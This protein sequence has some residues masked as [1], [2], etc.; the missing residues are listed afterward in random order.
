[1]CLLSAYIVL[2]SH[3][4]VV[5]EQIQA[6][7]DFLNQLWAAVQAAGEEYR[8]LWCSLSS[9]HPPSSVA[10]GATQSTHR[11][12]G[13]VCDA[14]AQP[15]ERRSSLTGMVSRLSVSVE[16]Q[17]RRA[18]DWA[19]RHLGMS[20]ED[21]PATAVARPT[22]RTAAKRPAKTFAEQRRD[23]LRY[24]MA[25]FG[26]KSA[27]DV[28]PDS[29]SD[30]DDEGS[31][32]AMRPIGTV[33]HRS[34]GR[35]RVPPRSVTPPLPTD[36]VHEASPPDSS[37]SGSEEEG[38][39]VVSGGRGDPAQE[40]HEQ[41]P[42][43]MALPQHE[44][45]RQA[46]PGSSAE[47]PTTAVPWPS[48]P[49]IS[50]TVGRPSTPLLPEEGD[51]M[52]S[53]VHRFTADAEHS[54]HRA[55]NFGQS[56]QVGASAHCEEG[57]E[58]AELLGFY[59]RCIVDLYCATSSCTAEVAAECLAHAVE[60]PRADPSQ[61]PQLLRRFEERLCRKA[62]MRNRR[63]YTTV[64]DQYCTC[65]CEVDFNGSATAGSPR[66][67]DVSSVTYA[68]TITASSSGT[69]G[70]AAEA[71]PAAT[72]TTGDAPNRRW[73]HVQLTQ[74]TV[75][76][77]Q[78]IFY[79]LFPRHRFIKTR[80]TPL[81]AATLKGDLRTRARWALVHGLRFAGRTYHFVAGAG[82]ERGEA[83]GYWFAT[84]DDAGLLPPISVQEVRQA[85]ANFDQAVSAAA[86]PGKINAR[87]MLGFSPTHGCV[88]LVDA[89]V[90]VVEDLQHEGGMV[91]TDGCGFIS[92]ALLATLPFAIHGGI[93]FCARVPPHK[94]HQKVSSATV[95][96]G[97]FAESPLPNTIQVRLSCK[98]GLFKGCLLVTTDD[99]LC[100][101][102]CVVM[103]QSMLKVPGPTHIQPNT[104]CRLFVN[105]TFEKV[106]A[107]PASAYKNLAGPN[108]SSSG[109]GN[110]WSASFSVDLALLL[111]HLGLPQHHVMVLAER[112]IQDIECIGTQRSVAVDVVHRQLRRADKRDGRSEGDSGSEGSDLPPSAAA[113]FTPPSQTVQDGADDS[114]SCLS[115]ASS[116]YSAGESPALK[117]LHFLF[118]G[119]SLNEPQLQK[120]LSTLQGLALKRLRKLKFHLPQSA[121]LVGVPDPYGVLQDTEVYVYLPLTEG[122]VRTEAT[123][124]GYDVLV[125]R[126]PMHH[127]GDIRKLRA[128][129]HPLLDALFGGS[130]NPVVV[131]ST[132]G[133]RS[134][135]DMMG[136]GDFD[137]DEYCVIYN[138][139]IVNAVRT[140]EPYHASAYP[141]S[142]TVKPSP[143]DPDAHLL[144]DPL[145]MDLLTSTLHFANSNIVG[146]C[147]KSW[148]V[149]ADRDASS[150]GARLCD[151]YARQA[152]DAA[153]SGFD[154]SCVR[155]PALQEK[156]HYMRDDFSQIRAVYHSTSVVGAVMDAI[157]RKVGELH[158]A[159]TVPPTADPDVSSVVEDGVVVF[160]MAE[161]VLYHV[162]RQRTGQE[163]CWELW[164]RWRGL[165]D[166]Y[167][168]NIGS[169]AG[170]GA[171]SAAERAQL[172]VIKDQFI[173]AFDRDAG[174]LP[175]TDARFSTLSPYAARR[176]L[177]ALVYY[178]TYENCA[179]YEGVYR[180]GF[181][182]EVCAAELHD[183]KR[184]SVARRERQHEHDLFTAAYLRDMYNME[185]DLLG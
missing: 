89:Q 59:R 122:E 88:D 163:Q 172:R 141:A 136:G 104:L 14:V 167:R 91:M 150:A 30:S 126:Y 43:R 3:T 175:R 47:Q 160:T 80:L 173:E 142:K 171:E 128:V 17:R 159:G 148:W 144:R 16:E 118:A 81:T 64:T 84:H 131:F 68:T 70:L 155:L 66:T 79:H 169:V 5:G 101:T 39:V 27:A 42:V 31:L 99:A 127:P 9:A 185:L 106:S 92:V 110:P 115:A 138:P 143:A 98:Q 21:P 130:S 55:H 114:N 112:E 161:E 49:A 73:Y 54:S 135:A 139:E 103:R 4:A 67:S 133:P 182:W 53:S 140:V 24:A 179:C 40:A 113:A 94:H 168:T 157:E 76:R 108:P 87:L 154:A 123:L 22:A 83:N 8:P 105:K 25:T 96:T 184:R 72:A 146:L 151:H 29:G 111:C 61:V 102:G 124:A 20:F 77:V 26:W 19:R 121:Y 85:L 7:A 48:A 60:R 6:E 57:W 174:Q 75:S 183:N 153:K 158:T 90:L 134:Q 18:Q 13:H 11:E 41:G 116:A 12:V 33:P 74:P 129:T 95:L 119:H 97:A 38:F 149:L 145:G 82:T 107:L 78:C 62:G 177:A 36:D 176:V 51:S 152:L 170:G 69:A 1:V 137:G 162:E 45:M 52:T 120:H 147:S 180:V 164:D 50:R 86:L 44:V 156:P 34:Q 109:P 56:P 65:H 178:L 71:V 28:P 165:Y 166:K 37:S 2:G 58:G 63:L 117:A 15:A 23:A 125:T 181:C 10:D 32:A 35:I 93:P 46:A 100:P 132:Q